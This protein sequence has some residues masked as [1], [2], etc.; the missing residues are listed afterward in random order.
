[1]YCIPSVYDTK[2]VALVGTGVPS[3]AKS[4]SSVIVTSYSPVPVFLPVCA[5]VTLS[6]P[7]T[8]VPATNVLTSSV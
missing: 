2:F 8:S 4:P 3:S 6:S 1:M 5:L 7:Y